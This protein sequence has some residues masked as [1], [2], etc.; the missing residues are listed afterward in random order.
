[1]LSFLLSVNIVNDALLADE[2]YKL[3]VGLCINL[4]VLAGRKVFGIKKT[5]YTYFAHMKM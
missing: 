5:L 3:T 4:W 2:E 1:M